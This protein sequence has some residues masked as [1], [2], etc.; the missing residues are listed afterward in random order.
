MSSSPSIVWQAPS[1]CSA[2]VNSSSLTIQSR[3]CASLIRA[4]C[5][6]DDC[7][8]LC[9]AQFYGGIGMAVM[10]IC[11]LNTIGLSNK[12]YMWIRV[13]FFIWPV[14]LIAVVVRAAVMSKSKQSAF[15][16]AVK[17]LK[18]I[19]LFTPFALQCFSS[20]GSKTRSFGSATTAVSYG[21]PRPKLAPKR[22][23]Q[24]PEVSARPGSTAC[25]L[26]LSSACSS[27][28]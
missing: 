2:W 20:T 16:F 11:I 23:R 13:C 25:T 1:F 12:S 28:F 6:A 19:S 14:I 7:E 26:H 4:I 3:S 17:I 21:D 10:S 24:C 27:T 9:R 8:R 15:T 18:Q 22:R 5:H